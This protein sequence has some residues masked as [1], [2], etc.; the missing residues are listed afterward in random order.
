[1]LTSYFLYWKHNCNTFLSSRQNLIW[2]GDAPYTL[3]SRYLA[4]R[5]PYMHYYSSLQVDGGAWLI[6]C[7]FI[8]SH[9]FCDL[10]LIHRFS[11]FHH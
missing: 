7:P 2:T 6:F 4:F 9:F 11:L 10:L 5:G 1:M 8:D 3:S